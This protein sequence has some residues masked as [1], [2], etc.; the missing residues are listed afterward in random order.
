MKKTLGLDTL[1]VL[2]LAGF[3]ALEYGVAQWSR[4]LAWILVG[5]LL[6]VAA[7]LGA[8]KRIK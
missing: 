6:M 2:A 3:A 7:S 5:A 8:G 1:D 4:P